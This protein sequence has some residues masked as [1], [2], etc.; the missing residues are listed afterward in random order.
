MAAGTPRRRNSREV[1]D[2]A[3]QSVS[4][5]VSYPYL[6]SPE[7]TGTASNVLT[8]SS[9]TEAFQTSSPSSS[10]FASHHSPNTG[11]IAG[12]IV[13]GVIGAALLAGFVL[14]F[15]LRRR[16]ARSVPPASM[17]FQGGEKEH[18]T[19]P[20]LPEGALKLYVSV[21]P[22]ILPQSDLVC[23]SPGP[24]G[25]NDLPEQ[26]LLVAEQSAPRLHYPH[27]AKRRRI[28]EPPGGLKR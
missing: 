18:P 25:S 8:A 3:S 5:S 28:Q 11:A 16:R 12:G 13:G 15:V 24:F 27:A 19:S 23:V 10:T 4:V 9:T 7:V 6:D 2:S 1:R 17:D 14:W 20:P 26:G 21:L 22:F